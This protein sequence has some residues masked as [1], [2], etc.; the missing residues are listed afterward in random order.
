MPPA[1]SVPRRRLPQG[2]IAETAAEAT[3]RYFG[4][5]A[6]RQ[7]PWTRWTCSTPWSA[8]VAYQTARDPATTTSTSRSSSCRSFWRG[9]CKP[10]R[11]A[12][13]SRLGYAKR[14]RRDGRRDS[15]RQAA[16][17]PLAGRPRARRGAS[18]GLMKGDTVMLSRTGEAARTVGV[19]GMAAWFTEMPNGPRGPQ[20]VEM[21]AMPTGP[22]G[23]STAAPVGG[24]GGR[25]G[26]AARGFEFEAEVSRCTPTCR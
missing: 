20:N 13:C 1:R 17:G 7:P 12:T 11:I 15:R 14:P 26:G 4:D 8:R 25:A 23:D 19:A 18:R 6:A 16:A 3:W 2:E 5:V 21:G 10:D 24:R 9:R 22:R